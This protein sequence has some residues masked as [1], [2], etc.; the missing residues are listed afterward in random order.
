MDD[1]NRVVLVVMETT[2]D[3]AYTQHLDLF[4]ATRGDVAEVTAFKTANACI[5]HKLRRLQAVNHRHINTHKRV[6][7]VR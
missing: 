7:G 4:L 1:A 3:R 5:A 2:A 6:R